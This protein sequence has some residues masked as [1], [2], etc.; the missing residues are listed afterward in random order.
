VKAV[1]ISIPDRAMVRDA[2]LPIQLL[3]ARIAQGLAEAGSL[4]GVTW[5]HLP[6]NEFGGWVM[7]RC[8]E[9]SEFV[10]VSHVVGTTLEGFRP[11]LTLNRVLVERGVRMTSLYDITD[12]SDEV[13]EHI[14]GSPDMPYYFSY[15]PMPIKIFDRRSV[16]LEG[17]HVPERISIMLVE[18]PDVTAAALGYVAAVR[19]C[20]VRASSLHE[21]VIDGLSPR[22]HAVALLLSQSMGDEQIGAM[23]GVSVRTVR[24]EVATLLK[25]LGVSSRFAAGTRFA[26]LRTQ[27]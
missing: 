14:I 27:L 13:A 21:T 15:G 12:I 25:V 7:D 9:S 3:R 20:A 22:Q 2:L 10:A 17:P 11:A 23:L 5:V 26:E 6:R 24:G 8:S 18:R 19:H 4:P 1:K 16:M